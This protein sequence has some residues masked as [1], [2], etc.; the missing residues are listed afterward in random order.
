MIDISI[1]VNLKKKEKLGRERRIKISFFSTA[2]FSFFSLLRRRN[3]TILLRVFSSITHH[4]PPSCYGNW[5]SSRWHK[6]RW[7]WQ[8]CR[9]DV[10]PTRHFPQASD[11]NPYTILSSD[12]PGALLIHLKLATNKYDRWS[13]TFLDSLKAMRKESF[14]DGIMAPPDRDSLDYLNWTTMKT[15]IVSRI[16]AMLDSSVLSYIPY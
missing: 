16:F 14:V 1:R 9:K 10:R 5:E 6:N 12:T 7:R 15:L 8:Q 3:L 13:S 2:I 4:S 11:L